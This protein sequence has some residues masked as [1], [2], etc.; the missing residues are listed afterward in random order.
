MFAISLRF[1]CKENPKAWWRMSNDD[2]VTQIL[3]FYP[4]TALQHYWNTII[5]FHTFSQKIHYCLGS[6]RCRYVAVYHIRY[7]M[8][9]WNSEKGQ[10]QGY[11]LWPLDFHNTPVLQ[12]SGGPLILYLEHMYQN[13]G[14]I[15]L[16]NHSLLRYAVV[17]RTGH[18]LQ[19]IFGHGAN[20]S[21]VAKYSGPHFTTRRK[22]HFSAR[23][24]L[25]SFASSTTSQIRFLCPSASLRFSHPCIPW[26]WNVPPLFV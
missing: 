7:A 5:R 4:A 25:A 24:N 1:L 21:R 9:S 16:L 12:N 22:K 18:Q 23:P 11:R 17:N 19:I 10:A 14:K 26:P 15:S 13:A 3:P 2:I 8:K 20:M 6:E